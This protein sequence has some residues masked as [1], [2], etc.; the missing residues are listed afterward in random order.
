[1][2]ICISKI[3][4]MG[5]MILTLPVIKAIKIKNPMFKIYV[6]A[7]HRNAKVLE[8]LNYIDEIFVINTNSKIRI[9]FKKLLI[10]RKFNFDFYI[11]LSPTSLSYIFCFFSNAKIKATLIFL[12]RYKNSIFSKLLVRI[13]SKIFCNYVHIIHR[14]IK[15]MNNEDIHQTKM[16]FDLIKMCKIS[17][18]RNTSIDI[19]LP[20][21]RQKLINAIKL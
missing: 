16:I 13:F 21:E 11:N 12:S 14:Y 18:N 2:K 8:N 5:D 15:L 3:D 6:L 9:L 1:M 7:S 10:I 4:K 20:K 19:S 17:C